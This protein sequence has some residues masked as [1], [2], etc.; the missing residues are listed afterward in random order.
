[1]E[2]MP[3]SI[4]DNLLQLRF[5]CDFHLDGYKIVRL[6]DISE[7]KYGEVEAFF[8]TIIEKEYPN[9]NIKIIES[10]V[11]N[12]WQSLLKFSKERNLIIIIEDEVAD[13]DG[14]YCYMSNFDALGIWDDKVYKILLDNITCITIED[15]Y[16]KM[17]KK[18]ALK[19]TEIG[20]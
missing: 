4:S 16:T 20:M 2:G 7:V 19:E 12:D 11:L 15:Y 18:Y 10:D 9:E 3:I 1:M 5:V 14:T 6:N 13:V 17:L 8:Q